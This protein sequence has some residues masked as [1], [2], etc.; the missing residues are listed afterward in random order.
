M[1]SHNPLPKIELERLDLPSGRIYLTPSGKKY[2]SVTSVI[3]HEEK[4]WLAEWKARVGEEEARKISARAAARGTAIH[5]MC[6]QYLLNQSPK[7]DMFDQEMWNTLKPELNRINN[8]RLLEGKMYSDILR[9]SG[10]TDCLADWDGIPSIIDFKTSR[11]AKHKE[12]IFGYFMQGFAYQR[13]AVE[14]YNIIAK[15][16]VIII[17]NDEGSCQVFMEDPENWVKKFSK[18]HKSYFTKFPYIA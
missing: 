5:E 6:E 17:A 15:Q 2:P 1:F 13:M 12:D 4:P 7:V 8:I 11:A 9:M 14:R 18:V 16:I 10:T 3:G